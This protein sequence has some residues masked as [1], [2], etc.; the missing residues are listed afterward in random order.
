M[1]GFRQILAGVIGVGVMAAASFAQTAALETA[2]PE[3]PGGDPAE[4]YVLGAYRIEAAQRPTLDGRLDEA[5]WAE[6]P[7]AT[8]FVQLEPDAGEPATERTEAR[9]L[10]DGSALYVGFRCYVRDPATIV[11][12]LSRRDQFVVSDAVWVQVDSY[13][14]RRTAFEFGVTPAG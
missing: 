13:F 3:G 10:Y 14:D 5:V 6:A 8:G 9:V 1:K 4:H 12:P 7:A 11:A 2:A